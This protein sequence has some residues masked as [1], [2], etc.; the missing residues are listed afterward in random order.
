MTFVNFD[1]RAYPQG[2]SVGIWT[3]PD[4]WRH[5]TFDWP[6][7]GKP[8]GS[9]LFQGGRG[10]IFEKYLEAF[11]HWH[12]AGW[13]VG[14]FDW[15]GQGGSG[16]LGPDRRVGH[17]TDFAPLIDDLAAWFGEWRAGNPAP[18]VVIAHS[19]GGHLLM[20]ALAEAR[21][22]PDAAVL[23]APMLGLRSAPFSIEWAGRI[24]RLMTR[25][26]APHRAAW[27]ANE[28][29]TLPGASR[30]KFLTHCLDRYA[31]ELWW[32]A[33]APELELGP[34]SWSWLATAY[35]STAALEA[36]G[37]LEAVETPVLLIA[38]DEDKL[39][40]PAATRRAAARLPNGELHVF[41][42]ESAHEILREADPVRTRA[43][44]LIDAFLD[45]RAPA[46]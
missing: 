42:A 24:A 40:D 41:G 35:A 9:I 22:D 5:R 32:K 34:P 13:S 39:V 17:A 38:A 28:R 6:A 10:D 19:M 46:R 31:D 25:I 43:L 3:A 30:Q 8:R 4:G 2:S 18:H 44:T 36:P 11:G 7:A 16:R 27:K 29:P 37:R 14:S 15:R 12:D 45:A 33:E 26:G 21:V 1:R 23:V 20:R